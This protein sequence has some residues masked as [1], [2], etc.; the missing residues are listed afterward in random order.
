M[1]GPFLSTLAAAG[2]AVVQLPAT[3]QTDALSVGADD[4]S[5][6]A[7]RCVKS[8]NDAWP[9]CANP[10][11]GSLA[12]Q[13]TPTSTADQATGG[14]HVT[15]GAFGSIRTLKVPGGPVLP[16]ASVAKKLS[17]C[18]P[19]V[20]TVVDAWFSYTVLGGPPSRF[21]VTDFTPEPPPS[22]AVSTTLTLDLVQSPDAVTGTVVT[23]VTGPLVSIPNTA[24]A[25]CPAPSLAIRWWT[26]SVVTDTGPVTGTKGP[27]SMLSV[28]WSAPETVA[29]TAPV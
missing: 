10:D 8:E 26:P 28:A 18:E 7:A 23:V 20:D 27:L 15:T 11:R 5:D 1:L 6:P 21:H 19:A 9:G 29:L 12:V 2:P 13:G 25:W 16:M 24:S 4:D 3:S 22:D 17:V 14:V